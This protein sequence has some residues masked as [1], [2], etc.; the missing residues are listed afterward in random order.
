MFESIIVSGQIHLG[1]QGEHR[2]RRFSFQD[3]VIWKEIFGEGTCELIHQRNGDSAPYPVALTIEDGVPYWYVTEVDTAFAGVGKCEIRYIVDDVVVKSNIYT[4]F[5][6]EALGEGTEEPPEP[7]KAWVDQVLE[8]G[9]Q[10]KQSADNAEIAKMLSEEYAEQTRVYAEQTATH[11][12]N[13]E[14]NAEYAD[15]RAKDSGVSS[16]T[17]QAAAEEAKK[18]ATELTKMYGDLNEALDRIID[19]QN[20]LIGGDSV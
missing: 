19:I 9:I 5:V 18:T 11:A 7:Q 17:A 10:A 3:F 16:M 8:V 6:Q 15:I 2:A 1:K 4:T 20:S 12:K 14:Q 13:V